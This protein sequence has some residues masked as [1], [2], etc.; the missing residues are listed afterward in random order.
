MSCNEDVYDDLFVF[1]SPSPQLLEEVKASE[2]AASAA[3][4][5]SASPSSSRTRRPSPV[6]R[7]DSGASSRLA[8]TSGFST[9][10]GPDAGSWRR[11][12]RQRPTIGRRRN[13][14]TT[15]TGVPYRLPAAAA[16][17]M[18]TVAAAVVHRAVPTTEAVE[19]AGVQR[20]RRARTHRRDGTDQRRRRHRHRLDQGTN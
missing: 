7:C 17:G 10:R 13:S 9:S 4:R 1:C 20:S 16:H 5:C 19:P 2:A 15:T 11:R 14:S 18:P 12:L 6:D 8:P 3:A